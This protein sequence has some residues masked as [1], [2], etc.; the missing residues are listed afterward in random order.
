VVSTQST[1]RYKGWLFF[2]FFFFWIP[3]LLLGFITSQQ[4]IYQ[5]QS[6][7]NEVTSNLT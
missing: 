6:L 7:V 2:F 3:A 5:Q 4:H 1:T